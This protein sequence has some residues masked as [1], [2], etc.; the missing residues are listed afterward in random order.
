MYIGENV[1]LTSTAEV[2]L[3]FNTNLEPRMAWPYQAMD[4]GNLKLAKEQLSLVLF[5]SNLSSSVGYP[6]YTYLERAAVKIPTSKRSVFI[7]I[8]LSDASI[9][10]VNKGGNARLQF[11]QK[12]S[13]FEYFYSVFFQLSHYCS[14]APYVTKALLHNKVHYGL[15]FTTRSLPCISELYDL[16][17]P[18]TGLEPCFM[19]RKEGVRSK[20]II[21]DNLYDLLT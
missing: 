10:K 14:K 2:A 12:Y 9:Q 11:K 3:A 19:L 13:Q 8:I 16:F 21:P 4:K 7:G 17:Y 1:S 6:R 20:K 18:A 5:G 15:G